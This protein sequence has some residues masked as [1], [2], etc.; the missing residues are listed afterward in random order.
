MIE[1]AV[2]AIAKTALGGKL[3]LLGLD[4]SVELLLRNEQLGGM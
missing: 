4:R 2:F 3:F 1:S